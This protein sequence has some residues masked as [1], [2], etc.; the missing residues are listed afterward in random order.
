MQLWGFENSRNTKRLDAFLQQAAG[1]ATSSNR[2]TINDIPDHNDGL[3]EVNDP[4]A[5]FRPVRV[6]FISA[7]PEEQRRYRHLVN[8]PNEVQ[9]NH[10][11]WRHVRSYRVDVQDV[12]NNPG[13][14]PSGV[15][16][17]NPTEQQALSRAIRERIPDYDRLRQV[18]P[19]PTISQRDRSG[20]AIVQSFALTEAQEAAITGDTSD[21]LNSTGMSLAQTR[22]RIKELKRKNDREINEVLAALSNGDW[23]AVKRGVRLLAKSGKL[24]AMDITA[25][26]ADMKHRIEENNSKLREELAHLGTTPA[27][28]RRA[29]IERAM[30]QNNLTLEGIPEQLRD[31]LNEAQ[32]SQENAENAVRKIEGIDAAG[33]WR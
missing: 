17:D 28:E 33:Q 6:T 24:S 15:I 8:N 14:R 11:L 1:R 3:P 32:T 20:R 23:T 12:P 19:N 13:E 5:E 22:A 29:S 10:P 30:R 18:A 25:I 26:Y 31:A 9:P 4:N 21:G 7:T 16:G 27:P 2:P